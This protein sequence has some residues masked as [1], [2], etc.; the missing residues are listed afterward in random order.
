M[1]Q[2]LCKVCYAR[3]QGSFYLWQI[4]PVPKREVSKYFDKDCLQI[5]LSLS[6]FLMMI[7]I[8]GK[9][10]HVAQKCQFY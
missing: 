10:N 9:S 2:L 6:A 4:G 7:Q 1:R 8:S 3:Y 5:F